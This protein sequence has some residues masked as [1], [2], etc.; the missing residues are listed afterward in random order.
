LRGQQTRCFVASNR[1]NGAPHVGLGDSPSIALGRRASGEYFSLSIVRDTHKDRSL[2]WD[3]NSFKTGEQRVILGET[4]DVWNAQ[5]PKTDSDLAWLSCVTADGIGLWYS[6]VSKNGVMS[7]AQ[8]TRIERRTVQ[9]ADV[10][11]PPDLLDLKRWLDAADAL[12]P[13]TATAGTP[14]DFE[15][16]MRSPAAEAKDASEIRTSLRH[17]SWTYTE[18]LHGDGRRAVRIGRDDRRFEMAFFA[19]TAGAFDSLQINTYEAVETGTDSATQPRGP[20]EL[21]RSEV[22]LGEKCAWFDVMPG[23]ADRGQEACK[24]HD[25]IV[26]KEISSSRGSVPRTIEAVQFRRREVGVAEVLPPS[27]IFRREKWGIPD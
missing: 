25:G 6:T 17:Q 9:P 16:V 19:D 4:C 23:V 11:P 7:S 8:A 13:A 14:A 27:E 1:I 26:V 24:T 10:L 18:S 20:V 3:Y 5:R 22:V 15:V 12:G 2:P 21:G